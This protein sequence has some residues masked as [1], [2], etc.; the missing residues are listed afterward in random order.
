MLI[1]VLILTY[2]LSYPSIDRHTV[3]LKIDIVRYNEALD[4]DETGRNEKKEKALMKKFPPEE[5]LFLQMP[6]IVVDAGGRIIVWYLPGAMTEMIMVS[7][8]HQPLM[9][10]SETPKVD[11]LGATKVMTGLL[12]HSITTGKTAK[13]RTDESNFH[14]SPDGLITPGCINISPAWFQQGREVSPVH[15]YWILEFEV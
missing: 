14:P 3:H 11:M 4:K 1:P 5:E 13:W 7:L 9:H 15:V 6:A 10:T 8:L 12:E 2:N